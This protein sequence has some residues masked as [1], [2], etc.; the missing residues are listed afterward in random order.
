MV[1]ELVI[2]L[3]SLE[4]EGKRLLSG[5]ENG[6]KAF[7]LFKLSK[8]TNDTRLVLKNGDKLVITNSYFLGMLESIIRKHS[9]KSELL[10]HMDYD[11]ISHNN[12]K[13]LLRGINRGFSEI[14]NPLS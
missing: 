8:Y 12:R 9:V 7:E 13:E 5:R 6:K 10:D 14:I 1:N 4:S 11:G 2:D 3:S